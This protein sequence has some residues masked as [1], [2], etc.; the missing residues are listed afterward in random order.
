[1]CG[2]PSGQ[3][4]QNIFRAGVPGTLFLIASNI[5]TFFSAAILHSG[6]PFAH[7]TFISPIVSAMPWTLVTWPLY[8]PA[9]PLTVLFVCFWTWWVCGSLERSWGTKTMLAFFVITNTIMTLSVLLGSHLLGI[10]SILFGLSYAIAAPTIAWCVINRNEVIRLYAIIPLPAPALAA[11]TLIMLWY[12]VG[13]PLLGLFALTGCAAAFWYAQYGRYIHRG[14]ATNVN[15]FSGTRTSGNNPVLRLKHYDR[16]LEK[17][18]S[19]GSNLS[20]FRWWRARQE[21]RRLEQLFRPTGT[22]DKDGPLR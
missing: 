21:R 1:M 14:Y 19:I 13:P 10:S 4:Y 15:P 8:G 9:N 12:N 7:L 2:S 5:V 22:D 3:P 20:P 16:E 11:I 6:D 17:E 18:V